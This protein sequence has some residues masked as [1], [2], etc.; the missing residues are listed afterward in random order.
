[1]EQSHRTAEIIHRLS[2]KLYRDEE[3]ADEIRQFSM[4]LSLDKLEYSPSEF[5]VLG[6]RFVLGVR[7]EF[8]F[9]KLGFLNYNEFYFAVSWFGDDVLNNSCTNGRLYNTTAIRLK[10]F[11]GKD[12]LC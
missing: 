3:F 2:G 6:D 9:W 11:K 12:Q 10:R 7:I 8:L 4:Q 1:M 5:F